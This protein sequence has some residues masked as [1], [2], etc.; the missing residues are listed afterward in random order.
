MTLIEWKSNKPTNIFAPNWNIKFWNEIIFT[1][2]QSLEIRSAILNKENEIISQYS[3]IINDGGTG[4]GANSLTSK[5]SKFNIFTWNYTWVDQI[6]ASSILAIQNLCQE[7]MPD[8]IYGQCWAN[9]MRFG[10]QIK[11]HWHSSY[12]HSFLGSHITVAADNTKTYY[13]N[14]YNKNNVYSFDNSVGSM[15]IFPSYLIH[16]TDIHLGDNERI[17]LAMDFLTEDA[18]VSSSNNELDNFICLYNKYKK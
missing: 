18:M 13:E 14:P 6:K 9:V 11:P 3:D 15:N 5:F 1:E 4:L 16:W 10:E 8:K 7:N 12:E 2:K 17:T